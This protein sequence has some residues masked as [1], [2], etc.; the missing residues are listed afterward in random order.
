MNHRMPGLPVYHQHLKFTQ[1]HVHWVSDI[2]QPFHPL[3]SSSPPALKFPRSGSFQTSQLFTSGG[4]SIGVSAST[5]G[6]GTQQLR[7]KFRP[8][9]KFHEHIYWVSH[10]QAFNKHG[11]KAQGP[12]DTKEDS[13]WLQGLHSTF[14]DRKVSDCVSS[15]RCYEKVICW[16]KWCREEGEVCATP[17]VQKNFLDRWHSTLVF[18]VQCRSLSV[19]QEGRALQAEGTAQSKG[20]MKLYGKQSIVSYHKQLPTNLWRNTKTAGD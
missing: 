15:E 6:G 5:G 10:W 8:E 20:G 19:R 18:E 11:L 16:K 14:K 2:I 3:S 1:T 9:K 7:E 4:Q 13:H 12:V 17:E